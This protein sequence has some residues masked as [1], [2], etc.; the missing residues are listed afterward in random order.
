MI[1]PST[2]TIFVETIWKIG[3]GVGNTIHAALFSRQKRLPEGDI[4]NNI[5][6]SDGSVTKISG[7]FGG[8]L[9]TLLTAKCKPVD[10]DRM[11]IFLKI[12]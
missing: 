7:E 9:F 6:V 11:Q 8:S 12:L 1:F 3:F 10:L 4:K 2:L 5:Y